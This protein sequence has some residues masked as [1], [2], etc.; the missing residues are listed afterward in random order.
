MKNKGFTMLELIAVILILAAVAL[1]TVPLI[2]KT[3]K[4]AKTKI[5]TDQ[6]DN[7]VAAAK[8]WN[9]ERLANYEEQT[10]VGNDIAIVLDISASMVD[11]DRGK[12]TVEALNE[13]IINFM[14]SN[15]NNRVSVVLFSN[16][17]RTKTIMSLDHYDIT[18]NLFSASS[19]GFALLS[20][21]YKS[22]G[23]QLTSESY[24]FLGGTYTQLGIEKGI[25]N[26]INGF[27]SEQIATVL[28]LTDGDP[29]AY[30]TNYTDVRK[31][32]VINLPGMSEQQY[33]DPNDI[34]TSAYYT[35]LTANHYKKKF[36]NSTGEQ[37]NFFTMTFELNTE[38]L[39]SRLDPEDN[40]E[41]NDLNQYL[42]TIMN[43]D[44][45]NI[46]LLAKFGE[47][48]LSNVL[49]KKL[50]SNSI[51]DKSNYAYA[52]HSYNMA[53]FTNES[54]LS[55]LEETIELSGLNA[56][57][58]IDD[59]VENGFLEASSLSDDDEDKLTGIV[60]VIF[61]PIKETYSYEFYNDIE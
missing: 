24:Q 36:Y 5:R 27:N 37:L 34:A 21:V 35:L 20:G 58:S 43:P 23:E 61:D 47:D 55:N 56:I 45:N 28:L 13:F 57:V 33:L 9:I 19:S 38:D 44:T 53:T 60:K 59:L 4:N 29:R 1:I 26:L 51:T 54:L 15:E 16:A 12:K 11:N 31:G 8:K 48:T 42:K 25:T 10:K 7:V 14:E 50:F 18:T 2:N 39:N 52:D 6:I 40:Y 22:S 49:Y 3:L 41:E 30:T 46:D 32:T 17:G